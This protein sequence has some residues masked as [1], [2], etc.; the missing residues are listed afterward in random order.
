MEA[1]PVEI[2]G[3]PFLALRD[4]A[5]L[6]ERTV[7]VPFELAPVLVR[8]DG[9]HT[10]LDLQ[11]ECMRARGG[12]LVPRAD[13]EEIVALLDREHFLDSPAFA[14]HKAALTEAFRAA[15]HRPAAHAGVSYPDDAGPLAA[16]LAA[17]EREADAVGPV[18]AAADEGK[19]SPGFARDSGAPADGDLALLVA[20]H[21]DLRVGGAT[22]VPAYRALAAARGADL[23]VI[24]GVAHGGIP[25]LFAA[26]TKAFATP[27][28]LART[29]REFVAALSAAFG[30]DLTAE[31]LVHR[32]DHTIEFQVVFLQWTLG[33]GCRI[34]P[35]LCAFGSGEA[36][37][38]GEAAAVRIERFAAALAET[39][40]GR[41]TGGERV[42]LV[43][44]ADLAHVGPRYGDPAPFD[45]AALLEVERADRETL[46]ALA[47]A[48]A[49]GFLARV[50]AD[51]DARR[52]C[53][54]SPLYTGLLAAGAR[55]GRLL[56]YAQGPSDAAGSVVSY[57]SMA[58]YR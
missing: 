8:F 48:D 45:R 53:G 19:R 55:G 5:G 23:A 3:R 39:V 17:F 44:S 4:P 46:E 30:E 54:F 51:G 26:S 16:R 10:F 47:A 12:Q 35:I 20:P 38:R 58:L 21:I 33:P 24:L 31:E 52:L 42:V 22:Y 15:P 1:F 11:V 43:A 27:L 40:A 41:R 34:V 9:R 49:A 14:A 13:L 6:A 7:A 37:A 56:A 32:S 36:A 18:P 50:A 57:A 25:G 29:D 28:G 2:Q